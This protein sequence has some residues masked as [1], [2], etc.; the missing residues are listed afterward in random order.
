[1]AHKKYPYFYLVPLFIFILSSCSLIKINQQDN[2]NGAYPVGTQTIIQNE[3]GNNYPAP[4][5]TEFKESALPTHDSN[6]G[7][8]EVQIL[9]NDA[10]V[11]DTL[12]FLADVLKSQDGLEIATSLD[13]T[14]APRAFSDQ[15]GVVRFINVKPGRYG[16]ILYE[17]MNSYL[18]LNPMDGQAILVTV[19]SR[20]NLDL[21]T[22]RFS[23]LPLD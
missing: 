12:F 1:M 21:G 6:L 3:I 8:V 11:V 9:I 18:L 17:G 4:A 19:G 2:Q 13:R 22:M 10:P 16:L 15:E 14:I 5:T 20:D 23:E 7:I